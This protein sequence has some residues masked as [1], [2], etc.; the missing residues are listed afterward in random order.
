MVATVRRRRYH[1][2]AGVELIFVCYFCR[3]VTALIYNIQ[4]YCFDSGAQQYSL[5]KYIIY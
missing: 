1:H 4:R 2:L 3:K 5:L